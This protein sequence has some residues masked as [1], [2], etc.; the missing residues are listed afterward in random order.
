M[1]TAREEQL[2][3]IIGNSAYSAHSYLGPGLIE[4]VYERCPCYELETQGVPHRGQEKVPLAY[5]GIKIWGTS[6][7][8][9]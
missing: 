9:I 6:A 3:E 2:A 7:L 8:T 5:K 4:S 1:P